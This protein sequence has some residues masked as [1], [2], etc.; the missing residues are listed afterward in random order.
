MSVKKKDLLLEQIEEIFEEFKSVKRN[1]RKGSFPVLHYYNAEEGAR[2]Q[3][4][5]TKINSLIK[6]FYGPESQYFVQVNK[7]ASGITRS[8]LELMIGVLTAIYDI[9]K[10]GYEDL[11]IERPITLKFEKII[12]DILNEFLDLIQ[13][14]CKEHGIFLN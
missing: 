2:I 11:D 13:Y 1:Y 14:R 5:Y 9:V 6:R 12:E 3:V 8:N 4:L 7:L 10:K